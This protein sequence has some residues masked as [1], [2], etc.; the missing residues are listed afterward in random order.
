MIRPR[1]FSRLLQMGK[2]KRK[3]I[4]SLDLT[5]LSCCTI[6]T[7]LSDIQKTKPFAANV[8]NQNFRDGQFQIFRQN[9]CADSQVLAN[10]FGADE[11]CADIVD[12]SNS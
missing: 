2:K 10:E 9:D 12:L 3:L 6:H 7:I 1:A 11:N 5:T 8:Q 4:K